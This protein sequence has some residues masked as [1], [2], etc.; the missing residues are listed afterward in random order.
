MIQKTLNR[1]Q[2]I[3]ENE[4]RA[5]LSLKCPMAPSM[6]IYHKSKGDGILTTLSMTQIFRSS[7]LDYYDNGK[8]FNLPVRNQEPLI[9]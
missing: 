7:Y 6:T 5:A 2:K 1:R 8:T 9:Q 3:E 4:Y